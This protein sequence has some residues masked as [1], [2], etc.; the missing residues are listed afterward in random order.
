VASLL[1]LLLPL[2]PLWNTFVIWNSTGVYVLSLLLIV[3]GYRWLS[4]GGLVPTTAAI[5]LMAAGISGYQVHVGLI[6]ALVFAEIVLSEEK[7]HSWLRISAQRLFAC[8]AS[9]ALYFVATKFAS[10]AGL[11]TWGGRGLAST[12]AQVK[13]NARGM[14]DNLALVPQPLLSFYGGLGAAWR[15][16]LVPFLALAT[17]T[18]VAW[19]IRSHRVA[20]GVIALPTFLLPISAASV[21]LVLNVVPTG[22]RMAAAIWIATLLATLPLL[23]FLDTKWRWSVATA[24]TLFVLAALP[25]ALA[26]ARNWRLAWEA[27]LETV[28]ALVRES[29]SA[30]GVT[31]LIHR[32]DTLPPLPPAWNGHPIVLQN[33]ARVTPFDYSNIRDYPEWLLASYGFRV[34]LVGTDMPESATAHSNLAE[35]RPEPMHRLIRLAPYGWRVR[36]RA[37]NL[38]RGSRHSSG[39]ILDPSVNNEPSF[40]TRTVQPTTLSQPNSLKTRTA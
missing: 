8:S 26:D 35:W 11:E 15:W 32:H 14:I 25:V 30:S 16:W 24:A 6:P 4:R 40:T 3:L 5:V 31:I 33:F 12:F 27:D 39:P 36:Q 19:A 7:L 37:A 2:H 20:A 21:V 9:V 38:T 22:P 29:G 17:L 23:Q 28:D 13:S 18:A 34:V 1:P 10:M